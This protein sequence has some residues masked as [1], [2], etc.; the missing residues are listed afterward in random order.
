MSRDVRKPVEMG[1]PTEARAMGRPRASDPDMNRGLY[2]KFQVTRYDPAN[3]HAHCFYFVLDVDHDVLAIPAMEA[4]IVAADE[5]GYK[6]LA[7]DLRGVVAT[8][9]IKHAGGNG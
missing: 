5:A 7:A 4:Y 2:R 6:H 3:K 8:A 1:T 9:K